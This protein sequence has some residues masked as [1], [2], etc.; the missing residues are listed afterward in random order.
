MGVS[1]MRSSTGVG[2]RAL[3]I[4]VVA[5]LFTVPGMAEAK[6]RGQDDGHPRP[7]AITKHK[8]QQAK[9]GRIHRRGVAKGLP[10]NEK[11]VGDHLKRGK[12]S[13]AQDAWN[14]F[15]GN[16]PNGG[17]IP[18]VNSTNGINW[19]VRCGP[20]LGST[21]RI[22]TIGPVSGGLIV[23]AIFAE[24]DPPDPVDWIHYANAFPYYVCPSDFPV[25]AGAAF[26]SPGYWWGV[27]VDGPDVGSGIRTGAT[28]TDPNATGGALWGT[29]SWSYYS[30]DEDAPGDGFQRGQFWGICA[31]RMP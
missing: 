9:Q 3:T 14:G 29:T 5:V 28:W 1:A 16:Y 7:S 10:V 20:A 4:T 24:E 19:V 30:T 21:Q 26:V 2:R 15:C 18:G 31:D 22:T 27:F 11:H 6:K 17:T 23:A 13:A 25:N 12:G 8:K